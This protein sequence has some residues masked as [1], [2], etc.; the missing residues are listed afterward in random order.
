LTREDGTDTLYRNV[1]KQ[2]P[3]PEERRSYYNSVSLEKNIKQNHKH[4]FAKTGKI[5]FFKTETTAACFQT[6]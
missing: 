2:L 4:I 1:G 5:A 6:L 3:H